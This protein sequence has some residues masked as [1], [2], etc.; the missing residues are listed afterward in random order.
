MDENLHKDNLEEFFRRSLD[1]FA[2]DPPDDWWE[3]LEEIIPPKPSVTRRLLPSLKWVAAAAMLLL[4]IGF[5]YQFSQLNQ[6]VESLTEEVDAKG[7]TINEMNKQVQVLEEKVAQ[8]KEEGKDKEEEVLVLEEKVAQSEE[9]GND[10]EEEVLVLE[11]K[12]AQELEESG[13]E[14]QNESRR[15]SH[16]A[17]RTTKTQS[18][19]PPIPQSFNPPIP[20]SHSSRR[21]SHVAPRTKL[22][23]N[24]KGQDSV[25]EEPSKLKNIAGSPQL[26][27]DDVMNRNA[28]SKQHEDQQKENEQL[29]EVFATEQPS[30]TQIPTKNKE[31][32]IA[33]VASPSPKVVELP[34]IEETAISVS[35]PTPLPVPPSYEVPTNIEMIGSTTIQTT[36]KKNDVVL[37]ERKV[38]APSEQL[39]FVNAVEPLTVKTT[40]TIVHDLTAQKQFR[41]KKKTPISIPKK[42][43]FAPKGKYEIGIYAAPIYS[44]RQ[45]KPPKR[46]R[47][48]RYDHFKQYESGGWGW[49]AGAQAF[50][51]ANKLLSLGLGFAYTQQVQKMNMDMPFK[52]KDDGE[53]RES[54]Y[55]SY[56]ETDLNVKVQNNGT[57]IVENDTIHIYMNTSKRESN[58]YF[59]LM[60]RLKLGKKRLQFSLA[61]GITPS[62]MIKE[63][64]ELKSMG[65]SHDDIAIKEFK[66]PQPP[67]REEDSKWMMNYQLST[68]LAYTLNDHIQLQ[69]N[70]TFRQSLQSKHKGE[71]GSTHPYTVSIQGGVSYNF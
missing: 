63:Q 71:W 2:E 21:T 55:T 57:D 45:V 22:K 27:Y 49:E 41:K 14:S 4:S 35:A 56:G 47:G 42:P 29:Q 68:G 58:I 70:P 20:Q 33:P 67:R 46:R 51:P 60:A 23:V 69:L 50:V 5:L 39:T 48:S 64:M 30:K 38:I 40:S 43:V 3:E 7:E 9:E 61:A 18:L 31:E 12:V 26:F 25:E 54:I 10:K 53:C 32:V 13:I 24:E 44:Y 28:T 16:F 8:S 15:T 6:R 52:Y 65:T 59:P 11:E 66:T 34:L 17:R 37:E 1:D 19:N 62:R 36:D